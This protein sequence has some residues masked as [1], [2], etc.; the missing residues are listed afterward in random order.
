MTFKAGQLR[1]T[2]AA[3]KEMIYAALEPL[4]HDLT[5]NTVVHATAAASSEKIEVGG[6][7]SLEVLIQESGPG[8]RTILHKRMPFSYRGPGRYS[9]S[10]LASQILWGVLQEYVR[11]LYAPPEPA[12]SLDF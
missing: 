3:A 12:F 6:S 10:T 4:P 8:G 1:Q 2:A 7:M 5:V 11:R 9:S